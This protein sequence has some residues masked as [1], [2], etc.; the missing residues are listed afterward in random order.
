MAENETIGD[1]TD[2]I[3]EAF[4]DHCLG[5]GE[6]VK[7]FDDWLNEYCDRTEISNLNRNDYMSLAD[8]G[9]K[10]YGSYTIDHNSGVEQAIDFLAVYGLLSAA[11]QAV[12]SFIDEHDLELTDALAREPP[13]TK[14]DYVND[15]GIHFIFENEDEDVEY[16]AWRE[17]ELGA[18]KKI[19][20]QVT[21]YHPMTGIDA[22]REAVHG[23]K[24]ERQT[25]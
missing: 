17:I 19:W 14:W 7:D 6:V 20:A 15:D 16:A 24:E 2:R 5:E 18:E 25:G 9:L 8:D 21:S 22:M 11:H 23:G 1:V 13:V 4:L 10:E 3:V 12:N